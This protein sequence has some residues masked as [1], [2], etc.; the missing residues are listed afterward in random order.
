MFASKHPL[1]LP[2]KGNFSRSAVTNETSARQDTTSLKLR[3]R[4][5]VGAHE[6]FVC[7]MS[8]ASGQ[9]QFNQQ[10]TTD[11]GLPTTLLQHSTPKQNQPCKET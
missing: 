7:Y 6:F 4:S 8:V 1:G 5:D 9:L 2:L 10:R 3:T 11:H